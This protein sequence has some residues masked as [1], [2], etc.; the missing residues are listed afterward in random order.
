MCVRECES[1]CLCG[2]REEGSASPGHVPEAVPDSSME[3]VLS[4]LL[5]S[6]S[7]SGLGRHET[8]R[9]SPHAHT[10]T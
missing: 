5:W 2:G 3:Q 1:V 10:H 6:R 9:V 4:V 8:R 7:G